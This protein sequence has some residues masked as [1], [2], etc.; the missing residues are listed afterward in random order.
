MQIILQGPREKG[1]GFSPFSPG[2]MD[3]SRGMASSIQK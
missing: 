2:R 1:G 3:K